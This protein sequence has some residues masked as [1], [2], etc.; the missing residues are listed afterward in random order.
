MSEAWIVLILAV[1]GAIAWGLSYWRKINADGV[2]SLDEII[3]GV[4]EA[5]EH[6]EDIKEA[7]EDIKE[8]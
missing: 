6:V 7:I 8:D 1:A 2:V 3:E 5:A 4:Q